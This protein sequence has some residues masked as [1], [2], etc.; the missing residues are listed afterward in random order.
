MPNWKKVVVS[1]SDAILSSITSSAGISSSGDIYAPNFIGTATQVSITDFSS[2]GNLDLV[3]NAGLN[4]NSLFNIPDGLL[5]YNADT[6]TLISNNFSGSLTG[7]ASYATYASNS[8]D[9]S[10]N[11]NNRVLTATGNNTLNA[12]Q[13]LSF[14]GSTLELTGSLT[15]DANNPITIKGQVGN[16]LTI[17]NE[18]STDI[19]KIGDVNLND[20]ETLITVNDNSNTITLDASNKLDIN[21]NIDVSNYNITASIISAS[22]FIGNLTGTSTLASNLTGTPSIIVNNITASGNISAS[23]DL[24]STHVFIPQGTN[25]GDAGLIFGD[26]IT[27]DS[28]YI[29]DN[30]GKLV[31]G[32]NDTDIISISDESNESL[33]LAGNTRI[34][35]HITASKNVSVSGDLIV[36]G[37]ITA[38]QY[39]VSSS[40]TYMTQSFSSGSTV[41]GDTLDDTHQFTGS[42]DITGSLSIPGFTDV[43]ASLASKGNTNTTGTPSDN[44]IA[45]WTNSNTIEGTSDFTFDAGALIVEGGGTTIF[46]NQNDD[47]TFQI[48]GSSDDNLLQ[49]NPQSGDKVGIGT[50]TPSEKLTVEGNISSSGLITALSASI[51]HVL[52]NDKLQGNGPGFQFFAYN[53]DTVKVKFANWY[54]SNDRQYG[55]GQLWYETWFAAID[56]QAGRDNRRIGFYLEEPDAGSTDSGTPGQHPTNA[57]FYVDITGSYIASGGLYVTDADF[58]VS[59][60][61]HVT[62]SGNISASGNLSADHLI[63]NPNTTTTGSNNTETQIDI[64]LGNEEYK[65]GVIKR[66]FDFRENL[67][68]PDDIGINNQVIA[69]IGEF[70][71]GTLD[72]TIELNG[73]RPDSESFNTD[74]ASLNQN[75]KI[76]TVPTTA[77]NGSAVDI[78]LEEGAVFGPFLSLLN[79][80][81][82]VDDQ[83]I[84][85]NSLLKIDN[86]Q[87]KFNV[88]DIN[89][90]NANMLLSSS[91][92][93]VYIDY[94][95]YK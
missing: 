17:R 70:K 51:D 72:V 79:V 25:T 89:I 52:V 73:Y 80:S 95:L 57:R 48:K 38:N 28:G 75:I 59:S 93:I 40:V 5:S 50:S 74:T 88:D 27:G 53:E 29:A 14:N 46:N 78:L 58:E 67:A 1:G 22:S 91:L 43:S 64:S 3:I 45:V 13:N 36:G 21:A 19:I 7:T 49:V 32:Y 9:I 76:H 35:G 62:A 66:V 83:L 6:N 39:I 61:G 23:G 82:I 34:T 11:V 68:S 71:K 56:N 87:I 77:F 41:F 30:E 42:V 85:Y 26:T 24:Y 47:A 94:Q 92:A 18:G 33:T 15:I 20:G 86:E 69:D 10:G 2:G 60:T 90:N 4:E 63:L 12:E 55:M 8:L 65:R 81:T 44:Q 54:S 37:N 84:L 31:I 16:V